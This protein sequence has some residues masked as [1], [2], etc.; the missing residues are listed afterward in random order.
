MLRSE[1]MLR[2]FFLWMLQPA[3]AVTY[4]RGEAQRHRDQLARYLSTAD[5]IDADRQPAERWARIALE[6][7]IRFDRTM[8]E[9]ADWAAAEL[10]R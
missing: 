1:R 5:L 7:G 10:E 6:A 4:L 3:D 9:W 8:A 2:V